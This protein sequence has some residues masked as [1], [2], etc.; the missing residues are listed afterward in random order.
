MSAVVRHVV[1]PLGVPDDP[2]WDLVGTTGMSLL[3]TKAAKTEPAC[4]AEK[5]VNL[6]AEFGYKLGYILGRPQAM[7]SSFRRSETWLVRH[8]GLEPTTR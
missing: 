6:S 5:P 7:E 3:G 4:D 1:R 2:D 8:V